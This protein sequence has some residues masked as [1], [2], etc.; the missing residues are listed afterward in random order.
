MSNNAQ[1]LPTR[2]QAYPIPLSFRDTSGNLITGWTGLSVIVS[3]DFGAFNLS[4]NAGTETLYSGVGSGLG[5]ILLAASEMTG[6][7]V[8][9]RATVTNTNATACTVTVFTFSTP[10][11]TGNFL[12][13]SPIRTD[14]LLMDIWV[15][16]WSQASRQGSTMTYDN[17]DGSVRGT[18]TYVESDLS[19][20]R[21]LIQ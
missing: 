13:Q 15:A 5:T 4:V 12:E 7:I 1:I 8:Q 9:V 17:V 20:Q 10:V 14:N 16:L 19:A 21:N 6:N 18:G 3:T 2:G 11:T